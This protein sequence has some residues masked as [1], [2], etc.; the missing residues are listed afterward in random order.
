M[1]FFE[2]NNIFSLIQCGF[3]NY[4]SIVDHLVR[5]DTYV[6]RGFARGEKVISISFDM[7]KA[8][9]KTWRYDIM[10]N[11]YDAGLRGRLPLYIQEFLWDRSFR[12]RIRNNLSTRFQGW[13]RS[14]RI[15]IKYYTFA[16]K[17]NSLYKIIPA[18]IHASMFVDDI[19][20]AFSHIH[21]TTITNTVRKCVDFIYA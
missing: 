6:R 4:K 10:K 20:I 13:C 16:I 9:D 19:Q 18:E 21:L 11:M 14:S 3:R 12:V 17:I 7:E 8:Y 2:H 15:D 5:L 1:E